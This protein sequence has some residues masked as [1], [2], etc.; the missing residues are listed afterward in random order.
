MIKQKAQNTKTKRYTH[1]ISI[2]GKAFY[3][4]HPPLKKY[5]TLKKFLYPALMVVTLW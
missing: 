5:K 2:N 1:V 3:K 4:R